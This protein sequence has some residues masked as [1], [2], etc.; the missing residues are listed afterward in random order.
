ML[1]IEY[2]IGQIKTGDEQGL[3]KP[4]L[5]NFQLLNLK[6]KH[7]RFGRAKRVLGYYRTRALS[8][9]S[10]SIN[11]RTHQN[12][13]VYELSKYQIETLVALIRCVLC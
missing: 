9:K 13:Y 12:H 7:N 8:N 3:P 5:K 10:A 2:K 4:A 1:S 6:K 11:R